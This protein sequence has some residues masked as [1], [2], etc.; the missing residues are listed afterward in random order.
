MSIIIENVSKKYGDKIGNFNINIKVKDGNVLGILGP[1]GA[2]KSTLIRQVMGFISSDSGNIFFD[3]L[4]P[5]KDHDKVMAQIGYVAGELNLF[6]TMTGQE[7]LK[8]TAKFKDNVD[9]G[10]LVKLIAYFELD[11]KRKIKKMSKGMKQ[12]VAIIAAVM[13]KPKYLILDEPTSGLDPVMQIRFNKL[14]K[15]LN[16]ENK[17]TVIVC[18]HIFE[19]IISVCDNI[20]FIKEGSIIDEFP[21]TDVKKVEEL[22]KRFEAFYNDEVE[23]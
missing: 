2:G 18:S 3:K 21:R 19:E 12:K 20:V 16:K 11:V 17:T 4:N 7:Y 9:Q 10:F 15:K 6:D 23:L 5:L 1:N 8:L 14:I 13:N 22:K